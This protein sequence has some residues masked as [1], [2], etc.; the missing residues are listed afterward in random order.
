MRTPRSAPHRIYQFEFIN[1]LK[2]GNEYRSTL[3][4]PTFMLQISLNRQ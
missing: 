1:K 4:S 3:E 2:Y